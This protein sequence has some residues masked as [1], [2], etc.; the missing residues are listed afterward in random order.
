MRINFKEKSLWKIVGF[1]FILI[2]ISVA[3][4]DIWG[5]KSSKVYAKDLMDNVKAQKP[6]SVKLTD[7]FI[8]TSYDFSIDMMKNNISRDKNSLISPMSIYLALGMTANGSDGNTLKEFENILS[9][10]KLSITELNK[11]YY[12]LISNIKTS[13]GS[14]LNIANSIWYSKNFPDIKKEFLQ[15]NANYYGANAYS[16]DFS[17]PKTV[18]DI[19]NWVNNNTDKYSVI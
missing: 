14:K 4:Y 8:N 13:D 16:A 10:N 1:V 12:S 6:D 2:I 9:K 15:T 19:N 3:V 17:S 11:S 7:S 18:T 5:N